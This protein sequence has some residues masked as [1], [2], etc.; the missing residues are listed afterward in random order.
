MSFQQTGLTYKVPFPADGSPPVQVQ[1]ALAGVPGSNGAVRCMAKGNVKV[2]FVDFT[3]AIAASDI[4]TQT[5]LPI[6][7]NTVTVGTKDGSTAA[8]YTWRS[9]L[10][11]AFDVLIG[12]SAQ[13]SLSNLAAAINAGTGA[14]TVY[15]TG[16]TANHDVS[17]VGSTSTLTATAFV[18]GTGG[19][20][21]AASTND[22][23][24]SWA[25]TTL[26]GG[27]NAINQAPLPLY[28]TLAV[29]LV[30]SSL[31]PM[32]EDLSVASTVNSVVCYGPPGSV[33]ELTVGT[34]ESP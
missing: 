33:L 17:A 7:G 20:S 30:G 12:V 4:L 19:N 23:D 13:A 24:G 22:P 29:T 28:D 9:A 26:Q 21:I 15:G 11:S 10:A 1:V 2:A 25:H 32:I 8:V 3:A 34:F 31:I 16:T 5:G 14:G 6:A 18:A 27:A